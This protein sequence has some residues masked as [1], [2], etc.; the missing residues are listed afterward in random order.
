M[1]EFRDTIALVTGASRGA[2]RAIALELG[3]AHATVYITGRSTRGGPFDSARS[4]AVSVARRI[5]SDS[6][7]LESAYSCACTAPNQLTTSSGVVKR[8]PDRR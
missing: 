2:G 4:M 3:A 8:P 5:R 1:A 7:H 6:A